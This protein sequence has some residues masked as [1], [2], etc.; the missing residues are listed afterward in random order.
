MPEIALLLSA[1]LFNDL[2]G[3][4]SKVE[5]YNGTNLL[6][7]DLS[8]PFEYSINPASDISYSISAKVCDDCGAVNTSNALIISTTV[9]CNDGVSM[10]MKTGL[11]VVAPV[12]LMPNQPC[13]NPTLIL[14]RKKCYAKFI[15]LRN[16]LNGMP[17]GW[18]MVLQVVL[19]LITLRTNLSHGGMSISVLTVRVTR[20]HIT[21]RSDCCGN[22]IKNSESL[23][24]NAPVTD[25][26]A[27]GN[28]FEYNNSSGMP[29]G[30][31]QDITNLNLNGRYVSICVDN[32]ATAFPLTLSEVKGFVDV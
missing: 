12:Q 13:I 2:D 25:F 20:V 11:I 23:F 5:F 4:I 28:V 3:T 19:I 8:T 7:T 29:V 22:I 30:Y 16:T 10:E 24:P 31:V 15:F 9:S 32:G 21:N 6:N 17:T 1:L 14:S 27:I 18:L 26:N